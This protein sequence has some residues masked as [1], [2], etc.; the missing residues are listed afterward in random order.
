MKEI[1][2]TQGKIML[3]DDEDYELM[4]SYK[5]CA[6]KDVH[7]TTWYALGTNNG[8]QFRVHRFILNLKPNECCDH[9]N[10]NGLDNRRCNL[11]IVTEQE[12]CYNRKKSITYAG[13]PCSS[14]YK[15]VNLDKQYNLWKSS[16]QIDKKRIYLGPFK[17]EEDA[18]RA[19]DMAAKKHRG[20]YAKLNFPEDV[21]DGQTKL[22]SPPVSS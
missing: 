18:A 7:G 14:K 8:K 17:S 2:L 21:C 3:I 1:L 10:G 19:Y 13:R 6:H 12:N 20:E 16:I 9:I 11:R 4:R 5:L 22:D 15:G